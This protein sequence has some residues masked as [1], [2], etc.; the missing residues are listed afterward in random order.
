MRVSQK[1]LLYAVHDVY[2]QRVHV[3]GLVLAL[4]TAIVWQLLGA[5]AG[6]GARTHLREALAAERLGRWSGV[7]G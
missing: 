1:G 2:L 6:S 3:R 4:R 5:R 7:E